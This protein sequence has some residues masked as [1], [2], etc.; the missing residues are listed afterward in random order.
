MSA[1]ENVKC[2]IRKSKNGHIAKLQNVKLSTHAGPNTRVDVEIVSQS[3]LCYADG[4]DDKEEPQAAVNSV[5]R[6]HSLA[7]CHVC[8]VL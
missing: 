6:L 5:L 3:P 1:L 7:R 2:K 4:E 8:F